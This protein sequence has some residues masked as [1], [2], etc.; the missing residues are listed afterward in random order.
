VDRSV[1]KSKR[2]VSF[3]SI[4]PIP[5]TLAAGPVPRWLLHLSEELAAKPQVKLTIDGKTTAVLVQLTGKK[6]ELSSSAMLTPGQRVRI[7]W[8]PEGSATSSDPDLFSLEWLV[9]AEGDR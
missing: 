4:E 1:E 5:G 2:S 3:T 7:E 6:M 8:T 9:A